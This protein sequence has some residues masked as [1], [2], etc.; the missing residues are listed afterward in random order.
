[1]DK[2]FK[3]TEGALLGTF[4]IPI[5]EIMQKQRK[6]YIQ[7]MIDLD[8][9]IDELE[10]IKRGEGVTTYDTIQKGMREEVKDKDHK[11]IRAQDKK[12]EEKAM[13]KKAPA[14]AANKIM[15]ALNLSGDKKKPTIQD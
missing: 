2:I 9:I 6:D 1:M 15:P 3:G 13:Q 10:K 11:S 5:G 4:S 7:N 14:S 8:V 12:A